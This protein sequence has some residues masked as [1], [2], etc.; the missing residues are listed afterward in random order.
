M[1]SGDERSGKWS[2]SPRP[3]A[4]VPVE[5]SVQRRTPA[6]PPGH[7]PGVVVANE[8]EGDHTV[9]AHSDHLPTG[10]GAERVLAPVL[11]EAD[12]DQGASRAGPRVGPVHKEDV[13]REMAV[14]QEGLRVPDG[15]PASMIPM[16]SPR[17]FPVDV[18]APVMPHRPCR[19]PPAT[20]S[21]RTGWID[22]EAVLR[23]DIH[24]RRFMGAMARDMCPPMVDMG[25]LVEQE[26]LM[27][28]TG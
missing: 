25:M 10:V 12:D 16:M 27:N 19:P 28:M 9:L 15:A 21:D 20:V 17:P 13:V 2:T 23:P 7:P 1:Q 5:P 6:P 18:P 8:V 14:V 22:I 11:A 4:H 3:V 24:W 26:L